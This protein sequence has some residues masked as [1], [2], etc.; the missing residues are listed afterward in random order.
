MKG[1]EVPRPGRRRNADRWG[2]AVSLAHGF[3]MEP[4][5]PCL[6]LEVHVLEPR[7]DAVPATELPTPMRVANESEGTVA[8]GAT[9][10]GTTP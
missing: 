4:F 10:H 3:T 7:S 8:L 1:G 6:P 9:V 2:S 5:P